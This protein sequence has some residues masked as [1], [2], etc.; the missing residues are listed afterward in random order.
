MDKD[1]QKEYEMIDVDGL[2]TCLAEEAWKEETKNKTSSEL[3]DVHIIENPLN[4]MDVSI[5]KE[6]SPYWAS[7]FFA[8][9]SGYQELI[10]QFKKPE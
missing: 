5:K 7:E 6:V 9:K 3:Y 1:K 10:S 2:A 4:K 8:I